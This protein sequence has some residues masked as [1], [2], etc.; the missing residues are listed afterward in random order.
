MYE[1]GFD[2]EIICPYCNAEF[3]ADVESKSNIKCPECQNTIELDWNGGEEINP[4][5][6]HCSSCSSK[7]GESFFEEFGDDIN[8][9]D[10]ETDDDDDF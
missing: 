4:C 10:N 2:F 1:D 8:L 5:S 9:I 7:C 6:G 3:I